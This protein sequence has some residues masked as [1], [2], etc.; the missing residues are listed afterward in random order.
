EAREEHEALMAKAAEMTLLYD[1]ALRLAGPNN[2]PTM[3]NIA[4]LRLAYG[5]LLQQRYLDAAVVADYQMEHYGEKY[6]E[7]GRE[8][9]F[10]AMAAFDNAYSA[11]DENDRAFEAEQVIQAANKICDRW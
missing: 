2:D 5:Y 4:R 6:P 3:V 11:A 1:L 7:V 10:L 8:A 9:G